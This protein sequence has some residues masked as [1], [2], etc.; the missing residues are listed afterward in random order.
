MCKTGVDAE[1]APGKP[2]EQRRS[3][4]D[5]ALARTQLGWEPAVPFDK[6]IES[7]VDFFREAR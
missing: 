5:N 2:G 4:L 7:T 3:C 1:H 6:G